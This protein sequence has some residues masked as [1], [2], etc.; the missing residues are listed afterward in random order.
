MGYIFDPESLH[1]IA[2]KHLALPHEEMMWAIRH[3]LEKQY[4]GHIEKSEK[5]ILSICGGVMGIMTLMHCS[6]SEYVLVY[7]TP[8][9]TE[10]YSGRYH[11][12]IYD[13]LLAGEMWTYTE[14]DFRKPLITMPGDMAHLKRRRAKG[15]KIYENSWMLEYGRGLIPTTLPFALTGAIMGLDLKPI[16]QTLGQYARL[17]TR[18]LLKG[19]I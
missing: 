4:P 1:A 14:E 13:V 8:V 5:W 9:G 10:G 19:K 11:A 16:S 2:R 6:L 17:V 18:E 12:D 7:G 3:D 15:V